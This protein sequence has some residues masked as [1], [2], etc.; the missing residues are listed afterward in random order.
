[1]KELIGFYL[2]RVCT[3]LVNTCVFNPWVAPKLYN[4]LH[5]GSSFCCEEVLLCH[6]V[7][8]WANS[9]SFY[10]FLEVYGRTL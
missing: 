7:K 1:M 9:L 8:K 5:S 4:C 6:D 10:T 3:L 2:L